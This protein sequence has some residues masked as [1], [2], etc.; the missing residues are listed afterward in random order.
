MYETTH[1]PLLH[2]RIIVAVAV[3]VDVD[4]AGA[5]EFDHDLGGA[6]FG[7]V[8]E[9]GKVCNAGAA[10]ALEVGKESA[11]AVANTDGHGWRSST[12]SS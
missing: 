1:P 11:L 5:D 9:A 8:C 12:L 7:D 4:Y 2:Q 10:V 6:T 3:G